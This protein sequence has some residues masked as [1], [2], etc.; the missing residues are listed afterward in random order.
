MERNDK[1]GK[2]SSQCPD[3]PNTLIFNKFKNY[4]EKL[5]YEQSRLL[6]AKGSRI[7]NNSARKISLHT[8]TRLL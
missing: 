7:V 3:V 6:S 4:S 1:V 2:C 5:T 8:D